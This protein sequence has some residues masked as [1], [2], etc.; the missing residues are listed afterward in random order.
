MEGELNLIINGSRRKAVERI[1]AKSG[2]VAHRS[3]WLP[4]GRLNIFRG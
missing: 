1:G 2:P 4:G 3:Q